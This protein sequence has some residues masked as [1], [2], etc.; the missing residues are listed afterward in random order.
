MNHK[1]G[2]LKIEEKAF[3]RCGNL[4]VISFYENRIRSIPSEAFLGLT[5][6]EKLE[7]GGNMLTRIDEKW[8]FDLSN[9][10]ESHLQKNQIEYIPKKLLKTMPH[11]ETLI[12]FSNKIKNFK[13]QNVNQIEKLYLANNPLSC[14]DIDVLSSILRL[15]LTNEMFFDESKK[16]D[17]TIT[18]KGLDCRSSTLPKS[19]QKTFETASSQ[20]DVKEK[21]CKDDC[22]ITFL[23]IASVITG[24]NGLILVLLVFKYKITDITF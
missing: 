24:I 3:E 21:I 7:L 15:K 18:Y 22:S 1:K 20:K 5:A 14:T 10:R 9:L 19:S 13:L 2:L 4:K 11:L 17:G 23:V 6:L 12:L 8:F 16:N